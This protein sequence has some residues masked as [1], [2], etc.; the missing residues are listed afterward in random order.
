MKILKD[1]P[2]KFF[3]LVLATTGGAAYAGS[4]ADAN[5]R[6]AFSDK[7]SMY[8]Q[9]IAGS[10]CAFTS[11]D[12]PFESRGFLAT[13][14]TEINRILNA[15]EQGDPAL[16]ISSREE[17][18]NI[19]ELLEQ[20][21][22]QWFPVDALT[23]TVLKGGNNDTYEQVLERNI[24]EFTETSF[25]LVSAI[26]NQYTN[27]EELS[28]TNAI[29]IQVAGRQRMYAQRLSFQACKIQKTGDPAVLAE[30]I[31]TMQFFDR[32]ASALR[33]GMPEAGLV[34]TTEPE[35]VAALDDIGRVWSELKWPLMALENGA[36]WDAFT[37]SRMYLKINEL[38]HELDKAVVAFTKAAKAVSS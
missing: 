33:D 38:T 20:I 31:E 32:S 21:N 16:G 5:A 25:R 35:L 26:T 36:K 10:A 24:T 17:N 1:M 18:E 9:R 22:R 7:L 15:L 27:A 28:L 34:A 12:A 8:S 37:Q 13:A 23:Q 14:G 11:A 3:A 19:L 2:C 6:L 30:L 4:D 29:R